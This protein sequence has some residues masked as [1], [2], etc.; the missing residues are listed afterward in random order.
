[1]SAIQSFHHINFVVRDLPPQVEYLRSL[2]QCKPIFEDLPVRTTLQ[3][4]FKI[5]FFLFILISI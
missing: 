2:L 5:A 3:T 1:M 4:Y